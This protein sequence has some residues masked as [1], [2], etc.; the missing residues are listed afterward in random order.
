[1]DN[2]EATLDEI[3]EILDISKSGANH[4]MRKII[5]YAKDYE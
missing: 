4:R 3:A 2:K 5:E 1:M